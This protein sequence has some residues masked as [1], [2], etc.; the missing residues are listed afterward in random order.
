MEQRVLDRA[1]SLGQKLRHILVA[2]ADGAGLPHV[3]AAAKVSSLKEGRVAVAA[4][5]CPG[6]MANLQE[7]KRVSLVI[8]DSQEDLGY[9]L[10][11]EIDRVEELAMMN[12]YIP[13]KERDPALPQVER[14]LIVRVE[15]IID[16]RHGPHSDREEQEK[17]GRE[18]LKNF[19]SQWAGRPSR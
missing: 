1:I 11:G 3:A 12:G 10:L 19:K 5:F 4:W 8:W 7:N 9:Q 15:K 2:T 6:T 16:F 18:S 13:G 17:G 14:R